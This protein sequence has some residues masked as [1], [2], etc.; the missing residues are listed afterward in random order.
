MSTTGVLIFT[1][2]D[3]PLFCSPTQEASNLDSVEGGAKLGL[4][5]LFLHYYLL[6]IVLFSIRI[7]VNLL[8]P[9]LYLL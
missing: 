4:Q 1:I 8:C 5:S 6:M 3:D 7:T 9:T 2:C